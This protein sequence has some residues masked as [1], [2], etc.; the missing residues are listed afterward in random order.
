MFD[1]KILLIHNETINIVLHVKGRTVQ[2]GKE[3]SHRS[4]FSHHCVIRKFD[5]INNKW[6]I[7]EY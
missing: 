7:K 4:V 3:K 1:M 2:H 5:G 6:G